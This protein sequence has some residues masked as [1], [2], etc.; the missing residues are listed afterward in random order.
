MIY[1]ILEFFFEHF[2]NLTL[3]LSNKKIKR[4]FFYFFT[5]HLD[6]VAHQKKMVDRLLK[7]RHHAGLDE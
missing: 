1:D 5:V 3:D 4:D 6:S 2:H 7:Y